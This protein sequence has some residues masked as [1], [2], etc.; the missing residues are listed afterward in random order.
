MTEAEVAQKVESLFPGKSA[1]VIAAFR[2]RTP[3]AKPFDIWSHVAASTVR[4]NAIKQCAA[5][6]ALGKAPAYLYWFT[7]QTPILDGRPRAFHCSEIAFAFDNTGRCENMTGGGE[8]ARALAANVSDAWIHFARSG[9]PSHP[10]IPK[11]T[12]FSPETV[13]TMIFDDKTELV[14]SPDGAEQKSIAEA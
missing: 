6:A 3:A 12:A 7:W 5:K 14:N 10:G 1:S 2:Q 4:E 9:D 13:P 8:D 11:W